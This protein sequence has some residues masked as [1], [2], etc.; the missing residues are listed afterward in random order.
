MPEILETFSTYRARVEQ[1]LLDID[2]P[3]ILSTDINI[4][5]LKG[6]DDRSIEMVPIAWPFSGKARR[7]GIA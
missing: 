5:I 4:P 7:C 3:I 6:G 2:K 1:S